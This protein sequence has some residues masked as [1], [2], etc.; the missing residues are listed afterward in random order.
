MQEGNAWERG[1]RGDSPLPPPLLIPDAGWRRKRRRRRRK[2]RRMPWFQTP[3]AKGTE[4][5]RGLHHRHLFAKAGGR[6]G[7]REGRE[8]KEGGER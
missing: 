7:G 4:E 3:Q 6:E 5:G 8:R 1:R 2:K